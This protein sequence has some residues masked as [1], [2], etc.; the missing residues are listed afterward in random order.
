MNFMGKIVGEHDL[1]R[2]YIDMSHASWE[3][4]NGHILLRAAKANYLRPD[5]QKVHTVRD[6]ILEVDRSGNLIDVWDLN[7]I[8][9]NTR[10]DL[11]KNLDLGAVCMN[12]DVTAAGQKVANE[13]E[14]P[15]VTP[16]ASV[17]AAT[18]RTSTPLPTIRATIPSS[19]PHAI[20]VW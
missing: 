12:V 19:S 16:R 1:P 10:D 4:P 20:R 3:M 14:A 15:S 13:P 6:H 2:G 17:P 7:K 18:G 8:L 11:I 5:G 9:D